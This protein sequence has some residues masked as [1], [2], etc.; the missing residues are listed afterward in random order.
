MSDVVRE[1]R[2][3]AARMGLGLV[4]GMAFGAA[5]GQI[6]LGLT[7]GL[8]IA[9]VGLLLKRPGRGGPAASAPEQRRDPRG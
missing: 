2:V 3:L 4:G 7:T 8:L 6:A 1:R 9:G 5:V